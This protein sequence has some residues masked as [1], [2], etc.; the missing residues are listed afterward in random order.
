[1][2]RL[3]DSN[4]T[5]YCDTSQEEIRPYVPKELRGK[6]L[7]LVHDLAHPSIRTTRKMI[8]KRF[9]WPTMNS[10]ITKWVRSC[11]PCQRNKIHRHT[12]L[13]PDHIP[14]P[15]V[16]FHHVHLDLVGP[17]PLSNGCKF[18]LTMIDRYTRWPEAVPLK[19][20]TAGTV[21]NAFYTNWIARFGAPATITTDRGVQFES[22]IFGALTN[23]FGIHRIRTTAY[24]P[25]SN[26]MIERWHRSL[27]TA[28]KCHEYQEWT[29]VLPT[30]LLG[31]RTAIKED[32]NATAADLVYGTSLRLPGDLFF[33]E[34][35]PINQTIFLR[36]FR[37]AMQ[38]LKP[39]S[40]AH[41]TRTKVF[42]H[43]DL[44][45][46]THVFIR[47]DDQRTQLKPAYEGP[48]QVIE[49]I[50]DK[51]YKIK[52]NAGNQTISTQR[53]KLA[54]R[55]T[56]PEQPQ[57]ETPQPQPSTSKQD[58]NLE[59]GEKTSTTN[60]ASTPQQSEA[61]VPP[62]VYHNKKTVRFA[63]QTNT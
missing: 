13:E 28:I 31:L 44:L 63:P 46:C 48:F 23:L 61:D 26:G 47:T 57:E 24:H 27:K 15:D 33:S 5:L 52:T 55:E 51:V 53:L 54:Y 14:V 36:G 4:S 59:T 2:L 40:T 16:R 8:A 35:T 41:H 29:D 9:V 17:L 49:K 22:Q 6:I 50:S 56:I 21:A 60:K 18:C 12:K 30:V 43:P 37:Q 39:R 3:E 10:D 7:K 38:S 42:I 32:I 1:M 34:D 62:R 19:D 25:Q 58:S 11:M 45:T 20:T